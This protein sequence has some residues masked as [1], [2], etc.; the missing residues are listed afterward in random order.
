MKYYRRPQLVQANRPLLTYATVRGSVFRS[1]PDGSHTE[2]WFN[3]SASQTFIVTTQDGASTTTLTGAP[4]FNTIITEINAQMATDV[5]NAV[6]FNA[7]G[8]LAIKST[9]KGANGYITIGAGTA[10]TALGLTNGD[11]SYGAEVPY[12]P[13]GTNAEDWGT[14]FP[15]HGENLDSSVFNRGMSAIAGNV[16]VLHSVISRQAPTLETVMTGVDSGDTTA[17]GGGTGDYVR[18]AVAPAGTRVWV[19]F[20]DLTATSGEATLEKFFRLIDLDTN[21]MSQYRVVAVVRNPATTLGDPPSGHGGNYADATTWAND[22]N[23]L[24]VRLTKSSAET[25][26]G[27]SGGDTITCSGATFSTNGVVAGDV[28]IIANADNLDE[29]DNNGERWII[30]SVVSETVIKVRAMSKAELDYFSVTSNEVQP[31]LEL[32]AQK[33]GGEVYGDVTVKTG[34][35]MDGLEL[36]VT[37]AIPVGTNL[38]LQIPTDSQT[39]ESLDL[40]APLLGTT[41]LTEA[42][43]PNVTPLPDGLIKAPEGSLAGDLTFTAGTMRWRGKV[44]TIPTATFAPAD[45]TASQTNYLYVDGDEGI[46]KF[47]TTVSDLSAWTDNDPS[48]WTAASK[49]LL[50]GVAIVDGAPAITSYT[51]GQRVLAEDSVNV[52][53]GYG[54]Q[55]A[56]LEDAAVYIN[57]LSSASSETSPAADGS[58]PHFNVEIV[59]DISIG[60][61]ITFS[62]P[63]LK[64]Y[65]RNP[66]TVVEWGNDYA[67]TYTGGGT[68]VIEDL[69]LTTA[70]GGAVVAKM[71]YI[72]SNDSRVVVDNVIQ[73]HAGTNYVSNFINTSATDGISEFRALNSTFN[74]VGSVCRGDGAGGVGTGP[75]KVLF[76]GCNVT[77]TD[78]GNNQF[79]LVWPTGG[80][81]GTATSTFTV[82]DCVLDISTNDTT[83]YMIVSL[84]AGGAVVVDGCVITIAATLPESGAAARTT[85]LIDMNNVAGASLVFTNTSVGTMPKAIEAGATDLVKV[86][87]CIFSVRA[88]GNTAVAFLEDVTQVSNCFF[89]IVNSGDVGRVA[90]TTAI[91]LDTGG[92]ASGN[93]ISGTGNGIEM[94]ARSSA[95]SNFIEISA[96][97]NSLPTSAILMNSSSMVTGNWI[98]NTLG[99][100]NNGVIECLTQT[101]GTIANNII[102]NTGGSATSSAIYLSASSRINVTGN[103]IV[104]PGTT[105]TGIE[106]INGD[107]ITI[108]GNTIYSTSECILVDVSSANVT[109][110]DNRLDSSVLY[111]VNLDQCTK[112][113]VSN[114]VVTAAG[115]GLYLNVALDVSLTGNNVVVGAGDSAVYLNGACIDVIV[116]DN[117]LEGTDT[118]GV[119]VSATSQNIIVSNNRIDTAGGDGIN[120]AG[121]DYVL[122]GNRIVTTTGHGVDISGDRGTVVGNKITTTTGTGVQVGG[123]NVGATIGNNHIVTSSGQA[124]QYDGDDGSIANNNITN[125]SNVTGGVIELSGANHVAITGN[126]LSLSTN[127]YGIFLTGTTSYVNISGNKIEN[128]T[129]GGDGI[130]LGTGAGC[131]DITVSNNTV[132]VAEAKAFI[133]TSAHRINVS[134]NFFENTGDGGTNKHVVHIEGTSG[135]KPQDFLFTGNTVKLGDST[136]DDD[137][138][139]M[140][141]LYALNAIVANNMLIRDSGNGA[142]R[143]FIRVGATGGDAADSAHGVLV[144]HNLFSG[145]T[146]GVVDNVNSVGTGRTRTHRPVTPVEEGGAGTF[147]TGQ[148]FE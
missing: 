51:N 119:E 132:I 13:P 47:T 103:Y 134:G 29:G 81:W 109:I 117:Y 87:N 59:S 64:L 130:V 110:S 137:N 34:V 39:L 77:T 49:P 122:N 8:Y 46:I 83:G 63:G 68:L 40:N 37:P 58:Y 104:C 25:I 18:L 113:A 14:F 144:S 125:S 6:A 148:A 55:F 11:K 42:Y 135:T 92:N 20:G 22:G 106:L 96:G 111:G 56:T 15:G 79:R 97:A 28:A 38:G 74:V 9:A 90:P 100:P 32:T 98:Q 70:S 71:F 23:V 54:G 80:T 123:T 138:L 45:L 82:R 73:T 5:V 115:H 61:D 141:I 57:A 105:W 7:D 114:N 1:D 53:V 24:G 126:V 17:I 4:E 143:I 72:D 127:S 78:A 95:D 116:N 112:V 30:T 19:G 145:G 84:V 121:D 31:V 36:I 128:V 27:I 75:G 66:N 85:H 129:V 67:I 3:V 146:G 69:N 52:T 48:S 124:I 43:G 35:F 88:H 89:E 16:D 65:G 101:G 136:N 26:T 2:P 102:D 10:N 50:L 139:P 142:G 108:T 62:A 44:V 120:C 147:S 91:K 86:D 41:S 94:G 133:L 93:F 118:A 99:S 60:A 76:Y 131:T 21:T 140:E 33:T 107:E 12:S